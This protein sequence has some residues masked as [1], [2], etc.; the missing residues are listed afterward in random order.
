MSKMQE[1]LD[2]AER[3]AELDK[4]K[5]TAMELI[6][7]IKLLSM[8]QQQTMRDVSRVHQNF[9]DIPIGGSGPEEM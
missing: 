7:A 2:Q 3:F 4:P 5:E 8:G 9:D 1:I 6:K